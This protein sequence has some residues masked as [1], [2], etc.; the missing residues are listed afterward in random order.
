MLDTK[1][2][3]ET[4]STPIAGER[5]SVAELRE[6]QN[7]LQTEQLLNALEMLDYGAELRVSVPQPTD[8]RS[9]NELLRIFEFFREKVGP[10][11]TSL[12]HGPD[13]MVVVVSREDRRHR[14][15]R[16]RLAGL[17]RYR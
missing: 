3:M 14:F 13:G 16:Q 10:E 5:R 11:A 15:L 2:R 4:E 17:G 9:A 7:V 6:R 1:N 8:P 12:E